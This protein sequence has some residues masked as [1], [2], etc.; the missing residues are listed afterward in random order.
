M[1]QDPQAS[2]AAEPN[3]EPT[4]PPGDDAPGPE[5]LGDSHA[6]EAES[7]GELHAIDALLRRPQQTIAKLAAADAPRTLATLVALALAGL[8]TYGLV[9]GSFSGGVQ[10]WAAPLKVL[11]AAG[12]C[13][14]ICFP[15]LYVFVTLAGARVRASEVLGVVAAM[16]ALVA[17]FLASFAPIAWVF[18]QSSTL[19][20]FVGA[21]HLV[22]W[23]ACAIA[24][25][26][27]LNAALKQWRA[28]PT[29]LTS[30]WILILIVTSLQMTTTLRP[31]VGSA[32]E[33]LDGERKFFLAHW[34]ESFASDARSGP[35][36][37]AGA[38]Y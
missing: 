4:P 23:I 12:L 1:T 20:T 38:G 29:G 10:W 7:L 25:R 14:A 15:S 13:G 21:L 24:S 27:V 17:I 5:S 3:P 6:S 37:D 2:P 31:I 36:G 19:V 22:V 33:L 18:T 16:L 9:I 35:A 26:R 28:R 34:A 8:A 11:A 30:A 32:P